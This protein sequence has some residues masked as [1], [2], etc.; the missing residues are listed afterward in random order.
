MPEPTL[1]DIQEGTAQK[2][3][4][5]DAAAGAR[6][7]VLRL[8]RS[9]AMTAALKRPSRTATA[10]DAMEELRRFGYEPKDLG[11]AAGSI[12]RLKV[13]EDTGDWQKSER[14]SNHAHK[15]RVWRLK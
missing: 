1:F 2:D 11:N 15:N 12:F 5:M 13:W 14:R 10:D 6:K 7:L 8:A 9:F 4:G 3:A